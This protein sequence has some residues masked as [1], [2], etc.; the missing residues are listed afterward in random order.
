MVLVS[1]S[2]LVMLMPS[3]YSIK[4]IILLTFLVTKTT[5]ASGYDGSVHQFHPSG[6][7]IQVERSRTLASRGGIVIGIKCVDGVAL[8]A[9]NKLPHSKLIVRG[10]QKIF[11]PDAHLRIACCG[12]FSDALGITDLI[13]RLCE[14]N[15]MLN[16]VV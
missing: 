1:K 3:V 9:A 10:K 4:V 14:W 2:G 8:I 7:V 11:A 16:N 15:R 5:R 12:L 6:R 13:K